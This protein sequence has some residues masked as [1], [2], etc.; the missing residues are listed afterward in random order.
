MRSNRCV[1]APLGASNHSA[2]E[3][4]KHDYYATEP[5]AVELL[6]EQ[7]VFTKNILEPMCGE[8]HIC[9]ILKGHGY[10]VIA[11]D[12]IDRGYGAVKDFMSIDKWDGDII[13]NPPYTGAIDY[14]AHAIDIIP[15]GSKV[16]MFLRLQFLE[17][18]ARRKYFETNPPKIIY[19]PSGRLNCAKNGD[20]EK[21]RKA[22]AVCYAWFI[23]EKGYT[24][25]P[26]IKWIN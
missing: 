5:K 4:E 6:L 1:F 23:W 12:L 18:K 15:N 8:G 10:N 25:A 2:E 9:D 24:G 3:R 26:Q 21:Y 14:V 13:S 7:E 17:G 11:Y 19:V 20:F 22:N 16:A